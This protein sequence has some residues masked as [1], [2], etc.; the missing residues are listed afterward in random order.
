MAKILE[1]NHST[2]S[3]YR[4]AAAAAGYIILLHQYEDTELSPEF[5]PGLQASMPE[6]S[7]KYII[8]YG[9]IQRQLPDRIFSSIKLKYRNNRSP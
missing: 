8:R 3:R 5:L 2:I 9:T 7:D 6:E 4:A 1:I